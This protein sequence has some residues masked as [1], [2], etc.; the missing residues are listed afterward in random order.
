MYENSD[1]QFF[2]TSTGM[3]SGPGTFVKSSFVMT[4]LINLEVTKYV[5]SD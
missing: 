4:F 3:Q 2:R 5:V 1:P